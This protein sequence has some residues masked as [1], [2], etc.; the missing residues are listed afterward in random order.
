MKKGVG[1]SE[2]ETGEKPHQTR[3]E[4]YSPK[5]EYFIYTISLFTL[6]T[7]RTIRAERKRIH[8]LGSPV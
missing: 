3:L 2:N 8:S 1:K 7:R 4:K 6:K 5:V